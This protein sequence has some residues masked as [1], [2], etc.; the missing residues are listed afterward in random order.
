TRTPAIAGGGEVKL[1]PR[2]QTMEFAAWDNK[3][4]L[5]FNGEHPSVRSIEITR[6]DNLPTVYIL[7]D[8][9]VCD[10][11]REP[12]NSWGQMLTRFLKPDVVVSNQ[13][14]SGETL[15]GSLGA[16]RLDKIV[17]TMKAGDYL[18]IQ[19]GHNDMKSK[20]PDALA[21]YKS[22][23]KRFVDAAKGKGAT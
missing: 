10:Q 18:L 20:A 2:E 16:R 19:F 6:A 13:A 15:A 17:S 4:T 3:L 8:S 5:E 1:K 14:E 21:R 7:G 11:P 22:D 23:L 12:W 9:T